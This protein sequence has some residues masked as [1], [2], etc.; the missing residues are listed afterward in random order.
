MG[1]EIKLQE[2]LRVDSSQLLQL[3]HKISYL[4]ELANVIHQ[5]LTTTNN[6]LV[7]TG[8]SMRPE[9]K[10]VPSIAI[11]FHFWFIYARHIQ[12]SHSQNHLPELWTVVFEIMQELRNH[13]IERFPI[14]CTI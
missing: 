3:T 13:D 2:Y 11:N 14:A 10:V 12:I 5:H 9:I 8:Q 6:E 7:H 1:K 4:H